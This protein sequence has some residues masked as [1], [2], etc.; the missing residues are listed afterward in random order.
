MVRTS[1]TNGPPKTRRAPAR[2]A[3]FDRRAWLAV[4][5]AVLA[6]I[7]IQ[8]VLADTHDWYGHWT[9]DYQLYMDV[10]RRWLAGGEFYQSWQLAGPYG[11][12]EPYGSV[13]YPP[14]AIWLFGVFTVLPAVLWWILPFGAV[15]WTVW[16]HHPDPWAWPVMALCIAWPPSIVKLVT[17]N[18]VMW[19]VASVALGTI[20]AWPSV[21]AMLKPSVFP[22]ALLGLRSRGWW[23]G[24]GLLVLASLPFGAMWGTWLTTV[25]NARDGG[26]LY[27]IQELPLL[28][29][30]LIAWAARQKVPAEARGGSLPARA[31][32]LGARG[33]AG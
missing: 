21:F 12:A 33:A 20:Y 1:G 30:P 9:L 5:A 19:A 17:G 32:R 23:L 18:P 3:R 29:L 31:R 15:A 14:V 26:L 2:M 22:F 6:A 8:L 24:F 16:R 11:V 13:L 10:T 7:A 25:F 27:S 4:T 28:A